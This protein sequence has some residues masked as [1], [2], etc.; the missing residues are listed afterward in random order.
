MSADADQSWFVVCVS[1]CTISADFLWRSVANRLGPLSGQTLTILSPPDTLSFTDWAGNV[2]VTAGLKLAFS[3]ELSPSATGIIYLNILSAAVSGSIIGRTDPNAPPIHFR[4]M[5]RGGTGTPTPVYAPFEVG[6]TAPNS[7]IGF[8]CVTAPPAQVPLLITNGTFSISGGR[9]VAGVLRLGGGGV[10]QLVNSIGG[11][12]LKLGGSLSVVSVD[13]SRVDLGPTGVGFATGHMLGPIKGETLVF[14]LSPS[15]N[16]PLSRTISELGWNGTVQ[17]IG[18]SLQ[19][20]FSFVG[21]EMGVSASLITAGP[22]R[23][24]FRDAPSPAARNPQTNGLISG[25]V[26]VSSFRFVQAENRRNLTLSGVSLY[27]QSRM[28]VVPTSQLTITDN[29]NITTLLEF[30][31]TGNVMDGARLVLENCTITNPWMDSDLQ[32]C[33]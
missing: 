7:T 9:L 6:M 4:M 14:D 19:H 25:S 1:G 28:L 20:A 21:C 17:V 12:K 23:V 33:T 29:S 27:Q 30:A 16:Q 8:F 26:G 15:S 2:T 5:Y 31:H 32:L 22:V 18:A 3:A 13:L 10:G 11:A 24:E